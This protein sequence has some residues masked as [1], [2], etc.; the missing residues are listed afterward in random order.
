MIRGFRTNVLGGGTSL[1]PKKLNIVKDGNDSAHP[2]YR[3]NTTGQITYETGYINLATSGSTSNFFVGTETIDVTKYK[4]LAFEIENSG[5]SMR[6]GLSTNATAD[7]PNV[8]NQRYDGVLTKQVVKIDISNVNGENYIV[9][10]C[11]GSYNV[12]VYNIWLEPF[13]RKYLYKDGIKYKDYENGVYATASDTVLDGGWTENGAYL[14]AV[15]NA[16]YHCRTLVFKEPINFA[17]YNKLTFNHDGVNTSIDVS[18]VVD[19]FYVGLST[20]MFSGQRYLYLHVSSQKTNFGQNTNT[21]KY[22]Q[23]S[24]V[25]EPIVRGIWL[26]K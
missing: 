7:P 17:E 19:S 12:K 25:G 1:T 16:N 20:A 18:D 13:D 4:T 15:V 2:L 14:S 10:D 22:A 11:W 3:Y 24:G 8:I 23:I 9:F 26:E 6:V 21:I 5:G